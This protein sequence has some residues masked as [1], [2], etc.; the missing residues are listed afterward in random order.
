LPDAAGGVWVPRTFPGDADGAAPVALG[1]ADAD[2]SVPPGD[3]DG[4]GEGVEEGD[5]VVAPPG[6]EIAEV[7]DAVGLASPATG[8]RAIE[9]VDDA[10]NTPAASATSPAS[11]TIGTIPTRLP[12]GKRSRQLGQK[13][14]TGVVTYPQFRQRTGRR[15]R[16][17]ACLAAFSMRDRF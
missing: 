12:S 10:A 5:A 6:A 16:A 9:P 14:E 8:L 13:P 2:G 7:G 3:R 11:A 15:F 4:E 17:T 1:L